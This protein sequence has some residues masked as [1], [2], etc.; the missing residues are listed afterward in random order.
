MKVLPTPLPGVVVVESVPFI[1]QRGSFLRLFCRHELADILGERNIAQINHSRA[2]R[3]GTIRGLHFQ[4]PPRAEMKLVRCVAGRVL[5]VAVD[6]RA[7]SPTF[8]RW[9]GEELTPENA[10][11]LVIPEGFAHGFQTL[12]DCSEL[13]YLHTEFHAPELEGG[14]RFDDDTLAIA[15]PLPV[16]ELSLRDR[17]LPPLAP[18]FGGIPA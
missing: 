3:A 11:M 18:G 4:S 7:D 2:T 13:L 5:D 14:V 8:L 9:H 16:S 12:E 1:D 15:W 10:R 6:L 17:N